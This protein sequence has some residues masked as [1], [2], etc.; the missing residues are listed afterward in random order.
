M[1]GIPYI[2]L[3]KLTIM[4]KSIVFRVK[5]VPSEGGP[6]LLGP[7]VSH[8]FGD[9]GVA[10]CWVLGVVPAK[11]SASHHL[12]VQEILSFRQFV[13]VILR[14]C[15]CSLNLILAGIIFNNFL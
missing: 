6:F 3:K 7:V 5:I 12:G 2:L 8:P 1:V 4:L 11:E 15:P 10:G 9:L 13:R 14:F